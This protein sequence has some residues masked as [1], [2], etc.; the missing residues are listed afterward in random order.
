MFTTLYVF[1]VK[2]EKYRLIFVVPAFSMVRYRDPIIRPFIHESIHPFD[3]QSVN[4]C[5]NPNFDPNI[6]VY[7]P[8]ALK[9][10]VMIL[11]IIQKA[12]VLVPFYTLVNEYAGI[13]NRRYFHSF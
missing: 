13:K 9:A 12:Q 3:H 10:P 11:G 5:I 7:F 1:V 8:R 4:I 6:Q 2:Q